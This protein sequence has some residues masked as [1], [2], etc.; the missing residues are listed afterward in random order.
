MDN[1][2]HNDNGKCYYIPFEL[3]LLVLAENL[4]VTSHYCSSRRF[5]FYLLAKCEVQKDRIR[6]FDQLQ[7]KYNIKGGCPYT[8]AKEHRKDKQPRIQVRLGL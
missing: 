1:H 6:V 3:Y 2:Y 4:Q 5:I 8:L 7:Y